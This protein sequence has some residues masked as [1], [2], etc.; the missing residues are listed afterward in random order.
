MLK[1]LGSIPYTNIFVSQQ[2]R[3]FSINDFRAS[4]MVMQG[5]ELGEFNLKDS[6]T[7]IST[8]L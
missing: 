5:F 6:Y 8:N 7:Y 3:R 1:G 2:R 4:K